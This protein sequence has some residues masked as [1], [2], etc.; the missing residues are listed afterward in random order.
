MECAGVTAPVLYHREAE[1]A[2]GV[3]EQLVSGSRERKLDEMSKCKNQN[4]GNQKIMPRKRTELWV[5]PSPN[6]SSGASRA[7]ISTIGW[8]NWRY[9]TANNQPWRRDRKKYVGEL[10]KRPT[11]CLGDNQR[12][13][14]RR[15]V[16]PEAMAMKYDSARSG[17]RAQL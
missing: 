17:S 9:K 15:S 12:F 11:K 1:R 14:I 5:T 4:A 3:A 10:M 8:K 13:A 7:V 6:P 16:F 2:A